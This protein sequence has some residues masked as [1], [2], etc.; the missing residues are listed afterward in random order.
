MSL[1]SQLGQNTESNGLK[2]VEKAASNFVKEIFDPQNSLWNTNVSKG[3]ETLGQ[4]AKE[5]LGNFTVF[6]GEKEI[7]AKPSKQEN[8]WTVLVQIGAQPGNPNGET[9]SD[10]KCSTTNSDKGALDAEHQKYQ[11]L[12]EIAK[13]TK[14]KSIVT[15]VQ[16]VVN[17]N[18]HKKDLPPQYILERYEIKNGNIE[19]LPSAPSEGSDKDIVS[20]EKFGLSRNPAKRVALIDNVHGRGNIGTHGEADHGPK[21]EDRIL[22]P[23]QLTDA[24]AEGLKDSG[25]TKLD[26]LDMDSCLMGQDGFLRL[27]KTVTNNLVA[28]PEKEP[29]PAQNIGR[30]VSQLSSSTSENGQDLGREIVNEARQGANIGKD[31]T[32]GTKTLAYYNLNEMNTFD[33]NLDKFAKDL[34]KYIEEPE[35]GYDTA[36][37]TK[38]VKE[39][40][41]E[42]KSYGETE[43]GKK[44]L[45]SILK[46]LPK[47]IKDDPILSDDIRKLLASEHKLIDSFFGDQQSGYSQLGGLSVYVPK[48]LAT[49]NSDAKS[50]PELFQ[51]RQTKYSL[52]GW[53]ILLD[54]LKQ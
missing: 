15:D 38:A 14:D 53:N 36:S 18:E 20:L 47:E 26:L 28:S 29:S 33:A 37:K 31:G 6:A 2:A 44:D 52:D 8:D 50:E 51:E 4:S 22:D 39:A 13:D 25:H 7:P 1:E 10:N 27:A 32:Q 54:E 17:A 21:L 35:K 45:D 43:E 19:T 48:K 42:A 34:S 23:K 16:I 46:N 9:K 11:K 30:I 24:I 12:V 5:I 40:F 41:S 3:V 49:K